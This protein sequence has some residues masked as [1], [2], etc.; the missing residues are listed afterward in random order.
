MLLVHE[1]D[2]GAFRAKQPLVTIGSQKIDA[3]GQHIERKNTQPLN[4]VEKKQAAAA[5]AKLA[6]LANID[7]PAGGIA[8]P[9]HAH[10]SR[11][12]IARRGNPIEIDN[13]SIDRHAADLDT[14]GG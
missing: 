1:Q 7:P 14:L 2:A 9:A 11:P 12:A 3:I 8:N 5:A 6:N 13:A 4:G 10:D